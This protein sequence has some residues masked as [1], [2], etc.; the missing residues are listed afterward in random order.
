MIVDQPLEQIFASANKTVVSVEFFP[1]NL[2]DGKTRDRFIRY[3][4]YINEFPLDFVSV[5]FGAGGAKWQN[6]SACVRTLRTIVSIPLLVHITCTRLSIAQIDEIITH[7]YT[8]GIRNFLVLRGDPPAALND[9][10]NDDKTDKTHED[11]HAKES[12]FLYAIDLLRYMQKI[13]PDCSY[14]V[15]GFPEGHPATPHRIE[16][17]EYLCAKCRAGA[18]GIIT[19]LC[20][21]HYDVNDFIERFRLSGLSIPISIGLLPVRAHMNMQRILGLAL[22]ARVPAKLL[23]QLEDNRD[24]HDTCNRVCTDFFFSELKRMQGFNGIHLY[25]LNNYKTA[26]DILPRLFQMLEE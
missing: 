26:S 8:M 12:E 17:M 11:H 24:D 20:F 9:H 3:A 13:Y 22:G 1:E 10:K 4:R 23:Q 16:E 6:T 5:T 2:D 21:T 14:F 25:L 15:A 19:Q 18:A 7:F